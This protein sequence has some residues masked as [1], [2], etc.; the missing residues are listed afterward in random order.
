MSDGLAS[1]I[2]Q[3]ALLGFLILIIRGEFGKR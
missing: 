1:N 2:Y 3:I